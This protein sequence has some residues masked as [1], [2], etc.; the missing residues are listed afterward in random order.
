MPEIK[1]ISPEEARKAIRPPGAAPDPLAPPPEPEPVV[2]LRET[3]PA[4]VGVPELSKVKAAYAEGQGDQLVV[5]V[6]LPGN[7]VA[8]MRAPNVALQLFVGQIM[9]S[10]FSPYLWNVVKSV[11]HVFELNGQA[12]NRPVNKTDLQ[13]LM[14]KLGDVGVDLVMAAYREFFGV[15]VEADQLPLSE[16]Q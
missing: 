14:N 12:V 13:K 6:P 5:T 16:Q 8:K 3:A 15:L 4:K 2:G 10:E 11:M 1:P 7:A 9:G